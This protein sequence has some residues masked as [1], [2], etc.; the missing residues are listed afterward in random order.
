MATS[1]C[2]YTATTTACSWEGRRSDGR[3]GAEPKGDAGDD[4]VQ[5]TLRRR[6]MDPRASGVAVVELEAIGAG[7]AVVPSLWGARG[8]QNESTRQALLALRIVPARS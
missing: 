2:L 6:A 7:F 3:G 5:Y 1:K 8:R 4:Q